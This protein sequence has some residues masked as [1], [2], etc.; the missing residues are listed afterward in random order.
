MQDEI[1]FSGETNNF[2]FDS[3]EQSRWLNLLEWAEI[4]YFLKLID[5][6]NL[7]KN[8]YWDLNSGLVHTK[9]ALSHWAMPSYS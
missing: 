7:K 4:T 9:R 3:K 8:Q 1:L 2:L 5:K 6:R